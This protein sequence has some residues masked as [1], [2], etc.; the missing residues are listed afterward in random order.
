VTFVNFSKPRIVKQE[1]TEKE[2]ALHNLTKF[3][4]FNVLISFYSLSEDARFANLTHFYTLFDIRAYNV[5][6]DYKV[7][8]DGSVE[9]FESSTKEIAMK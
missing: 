7:N 9:T 1:I 5:I 4:D 2:N 8:E 6:Y 3:K